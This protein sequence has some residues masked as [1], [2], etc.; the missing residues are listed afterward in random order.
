MATGK[1]LTKLTEAPFVG[2]VSGKSK[3]HRKL[4][5][6]NCTPKG[7]DSVSPVRGAPSGS[8]IRSASRPSSG[9]GPDSYPAEVPGGIIGSSGP[10]WIGIIRISAE[11]RGVVRGVDGGDTGCCLFR[12]LEVSSSGSD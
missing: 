2:S 8:G 12:Q 4:R 6:W 9:P 5:L 3:G 1:A 11:A 10:A 7:E